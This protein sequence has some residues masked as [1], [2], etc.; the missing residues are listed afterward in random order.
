MR[1]EDESSTPTL[2]PLFKEQMAGHY[3]EELGTM[4]SSHWQ[5]LPASNG[6]VG[7][8]DPRVRPAPL[9]ADWLIARAQGLSNGYK[10]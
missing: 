8:P 9:W 1:V 2:Q 7:S 4:A 5:K 3:W 10:F 6:Q